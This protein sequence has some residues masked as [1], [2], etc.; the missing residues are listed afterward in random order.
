MRW[1]SELIN[2]CVNPT[3]APKMIR[4]TETGSI[5]Q[6]EHSRFAICDDDHTRTQFQKVS[7]LRTQLS[8][9]SVVTL[10]PR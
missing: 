4:N 1:L 8:P 7:I 10:V 2:I 3:A 9:A 6:E 5:S